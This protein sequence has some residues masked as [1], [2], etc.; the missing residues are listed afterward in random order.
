MINCPTHM[1]YLLWAHMKGWPKYKMVAPINVLAFCTEVTIV[2]IQINE[3]Q[4]EMWC[5]HLLHLS[6]FTTSLDLLLLL[7][8]LHNAYVIYSWCCALIIN[9]TLRSYS[10]TNYLKCNELNLFTAFFK[11]L[12]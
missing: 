11:I 1:L 10:V 9:T 7:M 5:V 3:V 4:G 6:D 2:Y 12:F 8:E